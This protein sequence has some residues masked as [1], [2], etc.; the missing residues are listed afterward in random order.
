M[1]FPI[2]LSCPIGRG[3]GTLIEKSQKFLIP[4]LVE[5]CPIAKTLFKKQLHCTTDIFRSQKSSI[6]NLPQ[7]N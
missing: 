1:Y 6:E 4:S 7:V 5:T 3:C 2:Q